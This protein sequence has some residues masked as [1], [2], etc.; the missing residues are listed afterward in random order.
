MDWLVD[1][2]RGLII[3]VFFVHVAQLLLP[4]AGL[5][6]YAR[7][8]MG[9][10]VIAA[11]LGPVLEL[12][13]LDYPLQRQLFGMAPVPVDPYVRAG[14]ELA[15]AAAARLAEP[16]RSRF[17][18]QVAGWAGMAAGAEPARVG[19][20]W[21]PDGAPEKV[22]LVFAGEGGTAPAAER[23]RRL[24]AQFFGLAPEQVEV[25]ITGF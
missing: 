22:E 16:T 24:V 12:L 14:R 13:R 20:V 7:L 5:R 2:V 11:L 21:G 8:V 4:E 3:I 6:G 9:L 1:V 18:Q 10:L 17:E 25:R 15:A 23:V 19:V